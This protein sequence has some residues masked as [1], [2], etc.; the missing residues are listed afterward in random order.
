MHYIRLCSI[1]LHHGSAFDARLCGNI[2]KAPQSHYA[3]SSP[4]HEEMFHR[5]KDVA[6][7]SEPGHITL[8]CVAN[9]V[10]RMERNLLPIANIKFGWR[11]VSGEVK[12][13]QSHLLIATDSQGKS[14]QHNT[15]VFSFAINHSQ[16]VHQFFYIC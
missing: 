4:N 1:P 16:S 2:V 6:I 8:V 5:T 3:K 12:L 10:H 11:K 9:K 13:R 14:Q 15:Q 7:L